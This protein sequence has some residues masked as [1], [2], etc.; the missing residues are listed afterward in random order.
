MR[1]DGNSYAWGKVIDAFV[2]NRF[3]GEPPALHYAI[4][5]ILSRI[6]RERRLSDGDRVDLLVRLAR[7]HCSTPAET[8]RQA[9]SALGATSAVI[10]A[11]ATRAAENLNQRA[12][13]GLRYMRRQTEAMLAEEDQKAR[14]R[15][16][17]RTKAKRARD[18]PRDVARLQSVY[19]ERVGR[20][21]ANH[22]GI[23]AAA[24]PIDA[25]CGIYF[26]VRGGRVVYVGQSVNIMARLATHVK[27][28]DFDAACYLD[29]APE[30]LDFIESFYIHALQPELNGPP[31]LT[32]DRFLSLHVAEQEG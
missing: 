19:F 11:A 1:S 20:T 9:L 28:K 16:R 12:A 13:E 21:A 32:L 14:L 15:Q 2:R 30:E 17:P 31:P 29:A 5:M 26:L 22:A 24:F 6:E 3:Q 18:E 25:K 23:V 27:Q 7:K 4:L 8:V 10:D